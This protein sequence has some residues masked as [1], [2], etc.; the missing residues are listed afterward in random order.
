MDVDCTMGFDYEIKENEK[1][2]EEKTVNK[3]I[4]K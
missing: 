2:I 1:S 3:L 4:I